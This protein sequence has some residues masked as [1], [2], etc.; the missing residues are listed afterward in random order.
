MAIDDI[1]LEDLFIEFDADDGSGKKKMPWH[2]FLDS[3]AIPKEYRMMILDERSSM[4]DSMR[5]K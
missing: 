1:K 3:D 4:A 5:K 2:E